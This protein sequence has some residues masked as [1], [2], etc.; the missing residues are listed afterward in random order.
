MKKGRLLMISTD[1][2]I[3]D[4]KSSV[5]ARQVEYA[6]EWEEVHIITF[7]SK[8]QN[9][10]FKILSYDYNGEQI[11]DNCW[12]YSTDSSYKFLYPFDAIRIGRKIIKERNITE[13]TCQDPSLTAMAGVVLKKAFNL[14]LEIQIHGDIGSPYFAKSFSNKIRLILAK[15]YLPKADKIRVVSNRIKRYVESFLGCSGCDTSR[16]GDVTHPEIEVR[17]IFVD[18]ET[19]K[20]SPVLVDLNRKYK[21]FSYVALMASRLEKE[22]NIEL[23]IDAWQLVTK[24]FSKAGLVIVG[25][26]S[27]EYRLKKMVVER[28]LTKNVVF[29]DWADKATLYSYYKTADLFL[30]TSFFEGY[31]MTL[32]EAESAG[33]KI[34]STDVGVAGEVGATI[35]SFDARNLSCKVAKVFN[36]S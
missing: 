30:N 24:S 28:G 29:E 13:I 9:P 33:C 20:N 14:P 10:K 17:P 18:K 34:I 36:D 22:K 6:K 4:E 3:F 31:G 26:G 35:T 32:V 1:R 19:I 23:A 5:R 7:K 11:S 25:N 12:V 2:L 15:K 8:V 16:L 27:E 21:Q